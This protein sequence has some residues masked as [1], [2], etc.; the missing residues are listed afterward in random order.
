MRTIIEIPD[1]QIPVVAKQCRR[2]SISRAE[3][4][5]RA[6]ALYLRQR[7]QQSAEI[8]G[9]WKD[10]GLDGIEFQHRLRAEWDE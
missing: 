10:R 5:R 9:L 8:F 3:L 7:G 2:E 1:E 6:I 4:I